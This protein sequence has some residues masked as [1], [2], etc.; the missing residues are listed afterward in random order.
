MQGER[1]LVL[2]EADVNHNL[3]LQEGSNNYLAVPSANDICYSQQEYLNAFTNEAL[4]VVQCGICG[5][6]IPA[7]ASCLRCLSADNKV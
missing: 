1:D 6:E 3:V 7:S 4:C 5:R 2:P